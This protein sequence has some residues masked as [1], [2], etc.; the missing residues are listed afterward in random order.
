MA[1]QRHVPGLDHVSGGQTDYKA[2]KFF[3][4]EA[5]SDCYAIQRY[6]S[7]CS[8]IFITPIFQVLSRS[9]ISQW[10]FSYQEWKLRYQEVYDKFIPE[11]SSSTT[12][13]RVAV[14][15]SG[16]DFSHP[17]IEAWGENI[18]GKYN[19]LNDEHPNAVHD[20]NG[21]GTFVAGLLFDYA[22]GRAVRGQGC[23]Q[24]TSGPKNHC[25]GR[26]RIPS[27]ILSHWLTL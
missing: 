10:G 1:N 7:S 24:E 14:L 22:P 20:Q 19:W 3:D 27:S 2:F 26:M 6:V 13:V 11:T 12:P 23:R 9:I 25:K 8:P 21:H 4:D 17:E 18:K 15:D 16:I 5:S